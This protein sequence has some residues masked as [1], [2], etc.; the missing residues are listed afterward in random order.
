MQHEI[1][2]VLARDAPSPVVQLAVMVAAEQ[3][4]AVDIGAALLGV[5]F[6]NV[7]CFAVRGGAIAA[8][9]PASA[10]THRQGDALCRREQAMLPSDVQW[11]PRGST[12]ICTVPVSQMRCSTVPNG[13]G[14]P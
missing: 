11:V 12:V 14:M 13:N 2:L 6:V 3:D 5:P 10:V 1:A 9:P 8:S 7:V 4:S